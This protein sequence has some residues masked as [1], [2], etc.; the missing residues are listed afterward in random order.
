MALYYDGEVTVF[1]EN[2]TIDANS[3][4]KMENGP[5]T[6]RP[7]V[8]AMPTD[9]QILTAAYQAFNARDIASPLAL[10]H[11]QVRPRAVAA[12]LPSFHSFMIENDGKLRSVRPKTPFLYLR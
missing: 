12:G 2:P 11:P 8:I 10:M 7:G 1:V 5:G 6:G 9:Q 4:P 3:F